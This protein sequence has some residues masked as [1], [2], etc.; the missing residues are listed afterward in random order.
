MPLLTI[1]V[2]TYNRAGYLELCLGRIQQEIESLSEDDRGLVRVYV[3]DNASPDDTPNVI[4]RF[5]ATAKGAF[6]AVR[7]RANIGAEGNFTQCYASAATPYVWVLGDDD[8]I[9]RNALH[10]VLE[11]LRRQEVDVLYLN[12]YWYKESFSEKLDHKGKHGAVRCRDSLEFARRTSVM[13]TFTSAL[14]ARTGVDLELYSEVVAGSNL[15]QFGWL[16]P[17]LRDGACFV[18]IQDPVIAAKGSNSCGYELVK[19]FGHGLKRITDDILRDKPEVAGA[20][21]NAIIMD[22]FPGFIID[23]RKG[24]HR[25]DDREMAVGLKQVFGSNWRYHVF[26]APLFVLPVPLLSYGNLIARVARRLFRI[27]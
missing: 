19:V 8:L 4:A 21:Q 3:S 13:L 6:D 9:V 22:F 2:P 17:L 5:R 12:N 14:I 26:L 18:I 15:P 11:V 27:S 16:L 25:F 10:K 20:I 24:A 1:A 7:N 23:F